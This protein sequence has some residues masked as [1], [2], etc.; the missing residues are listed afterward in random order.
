VGN[1]YALG[2][3]SFS[4]NSRFRPFPLAFDPIPVLSSYVAREFFVEGRAMI[5]EE[6]RLNLLRDG[7]RKVMNGGDPYEDDLE[8]ADGLGTESAESLPSSDGSGF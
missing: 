2:D 3:D 1:L 6:A 5:P 8:P 4:K 7:G